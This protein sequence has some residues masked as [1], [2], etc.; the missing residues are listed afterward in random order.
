MYNIEVN[1]VFVRVTYYFKSMCPYLLQIII[2]VKMNAFQ[3][4]GQ[5]SVILLAHFAF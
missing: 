4:C 5:K 1:T 3:L 2:V